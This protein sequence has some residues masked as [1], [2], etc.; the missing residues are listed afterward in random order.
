MDQT[1]RNAGALKRLPNT[2]FWIAV[3]F[4]AL[5]L[6]FGS[7][8]IVLDFRYYRL[9]LFKNL[10]PL[11]AII[12]AGGLFISLAVLCERPGRFQRAFVIVRNCLIALISLVIALVLLLSALG[13]LH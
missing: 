7:T 10:F 4:G 3:S 2:G 6:V 5:L 11:L 9:D 12:A 1:S 8:L 13:P